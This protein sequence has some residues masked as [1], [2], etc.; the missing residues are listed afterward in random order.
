[1]PGP[2]LLPFYKLHLIQVGT[3]KLSDFILTFIYIESLTCMDVIAQKFLLKRQLEL[4]VHMDV[5]YSLIDNLQ[6]LCFS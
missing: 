2:R 3:I 6:V 5:M 4:I 1:V